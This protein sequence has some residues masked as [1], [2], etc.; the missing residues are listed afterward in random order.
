[1]CVLLYYVHDIQVL[2]HVP[3]YDAIKRVKQCGFTLLSVPRIVCL[4]LPEAFFSSISYRKVNLLL[5]KVHL[6]ASSRQLQDIHV[7]LIYSVSK[8]RHPVSFLLAK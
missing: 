3:L 1:M 8:S 7:L 5:G 6:R 2:F 4:A